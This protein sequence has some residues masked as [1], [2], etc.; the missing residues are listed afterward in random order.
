MLGNP[1]Q[2]SETER[3]DL[4][5]TQRL[6]TSLE[7]SLLALRS[8]DVLRNVVGLHVVDHYLA[9]KDAERIM[10]RQMSERELDL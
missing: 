8:D 7:E 10:L 2:L 4:G 9:M 3:T 6:P 1:S 5:I